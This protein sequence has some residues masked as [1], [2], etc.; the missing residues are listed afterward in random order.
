ML[1]PLLLR[2]QLLNSFEFHVPLSG[3]R[4]RRERH[5]LSCVFLV[6]LKTLFLNSVLLLFEQFTSINILCLIPFVGARTPLQML[7]TIELATR[8]SYLPQELSLLTH[9]EVVVQKV[10][11]VPLIEKLQPVF[12]LLF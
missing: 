9:V 5:E 3:C 11:N 7:L 10:S 12:V 8:G 6:Y 1:F 2:L 4:Q